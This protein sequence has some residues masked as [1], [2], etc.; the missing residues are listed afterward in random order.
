MIFHSYLQNNDI[1]QKIS[2]EQGL[3]ESYLKHDTSIPIP[4][5]QSEYVFCKILMECSRVADLFD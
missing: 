2:S 4:V 3:I 5:I 1:I